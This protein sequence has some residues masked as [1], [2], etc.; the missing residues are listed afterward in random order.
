MM[1]DLPLPEVPL[2]W[3]IKYT[4]VMANPD[5]TPTTPNVGY[6]LTATGLE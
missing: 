2:I 3:Y 1:L 6:E 4:A 5:P